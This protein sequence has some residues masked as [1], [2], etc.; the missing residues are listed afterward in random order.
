M[1]GGQDGGTGEELFAPGIGRM[2]AANRA[3]RRAPRRGGRCAATMLAGMALMLA[4]LGA[5]CFYPPTQKPPA[6]D[7]NQVALEYPYDIVW[8]AVHEVVR[9]NH[10]TVNADDPNRGIVEAQSSHFTLADADC[11]K[12]KGISGKYASEPDRAATAVYYFKVKPKGTEETTVNVQATFSAP[13][14]VPL[15]TPRSEQCVSRGKAEAR[16]LGEIAE[17][18]ATMRR[19]VFTKPGS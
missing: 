12:L 5:G 1:A 18:A 15:H 4:G 8:D 13:L 9:K 19:P 17:T 3:V 2:R 6:P 11:G 14:Y 16:L 10:L 7:A